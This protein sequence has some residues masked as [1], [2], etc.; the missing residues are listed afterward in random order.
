M[1]PMKKYYRVIYL[2]LS[3]FCSRAVNAQNRHNDQLIVD[4]YSGC[5]APNDSSEERLVTIHDKTFQWINRAGGK[6]T[7]RG[8]WR[9]TSRMGIPFKA[10]VIIL[11]FSNGA[12]AKYEVDHTTMATI[13]VS[14]KR[15]FS[16][17]ACN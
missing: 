15:R 1:I 16:R 10:T 6:D 7:L 5:W 13:Y 8:K 12:R 17:V 14:E 3:L 2:L 4:S 11:K 9:I